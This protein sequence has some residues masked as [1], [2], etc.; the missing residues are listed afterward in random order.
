MHLQIICPGSIRDQQVASLVRF[1][2]TT[3]LTKRK[4]G[5]NCREPVCFKSGKCDSALY[6]KL[7]GV[8]WWAGARPSNQ[9]FPWESGLE[10]VPRLL[11]LALAK[12][13][14]PWSETVDVY[15]LSSR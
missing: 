15:C 3:V 9:V 11:G 1:T 8:K 12:T 6:G 13:P 10:N 7:T 14:S 2:T 4:K 5:G